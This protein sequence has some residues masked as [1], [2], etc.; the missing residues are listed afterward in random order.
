MGRHHWSQKQ[1]EC[2]D[3]IENGCKRYYPSTPVTK[4]MYLDTVHT[5]DDRYKVKLQTSSEWRYFHVPNVPEQFIR[6]EVSKFDNA[7]D[8][9]NHHQSQLEDIPLCGFHPIPLKNN[10]NYRIRLAKQRS[11][12][13]SAFAQLVNAASVLDT[14]D[15]NRLQEI[16]HDVGR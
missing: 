6:E 4:D 3:R 12:N 15:Y 11:S 10:S 9:V 2:F 7:S 5:F 14:A 8:D 13:L 1:L 16:P